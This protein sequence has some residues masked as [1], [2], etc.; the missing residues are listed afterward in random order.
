MQ[1]LKNSVKTFYQKNRLLI[2]IGLGFIL[3]MQICS[4]GGKVNTNPDE[5]IREIE[6]SV[7]DTDIKPL[8]EIYQE[9][10][11]D[12]KT[13]NPEMISLFILIGFVLMFYVA[14]KRGWIKKIV[15]SVVWVSLSIKRHKQ[16]KERMAT[17]LVLNQTRESITFISPVISFG[18][19]FKKS[20]KFRIKSGVGQ[21]IF[22]LILLPGT[23]HQIV[24]NL[25]TFIQK[26]GDLSAY[27]W[28]RLE[29]GG[30][31]QKMYTSFW[32]YLF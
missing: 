20:R 8:Q 16:S 5:Q 22:P 32:K 24:I 7:D 29:I 12:N 23:S 4:Q 26:A 18:G 1:H 2:I 14:T 6:R 13:A 30:K 21:D 19:L 3:M 15:P 17:L 25:D 9:E 27:S 28:V 31:S 11:R 10:V